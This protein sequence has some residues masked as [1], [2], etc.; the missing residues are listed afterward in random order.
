M[1][2][3]DRPGAATCRT[4][5]GAGGPATRSSC[6]PLSPKSPITLALA[7]GVALALAAPTERASAQEAQAPR[8]VV[9]LQEALD[10]AL[11][12]NKDLA[13]YEYRVAEQQGRLEQAGLLPNPQLD[14]LIEDVAGSG[15]YE[16]FDS[17]QTTISLGWVLE[18]WL[19][20]GRVR[21]AKAGAELVSAKARILRIEVAADTA[22][23]FLASL[24]SQTRLER[25]DAAIELAERTVAA[26]TRRVRAGKAPTVELARAEAELAMDRLARDDV[27]HELSAAHH[28]LAAQWGETEPQF[29]HVAGD[30]LTLPV[31]KARAEL[32]AGLER[33]PQLERYATEER[34]AQANLRLAEARRWPAPK[35]LLGV[36]RYEAT[37]DM[38]LVAGVS[39][40]LPLLNRNQGEVAASRSSISRARAQTD[41][42][43]VRLQTTLFE[44]YEELQHYF[45][46]AETL[47]IEVIPRL[48][49][50]LEGTR[51]AYERGRYG[52]FELRSVQADLLQAESD[53]VEA[54]AGAHRLVIALERLAGERVVE[55]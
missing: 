52:Y 37:D 15:P 32:T 31:I 18:G 14:V 44:L 10:R 23:H 16:G 50:A 36:R 45:H 24:A 27:T 53:L 6:R 51:Q 34:L 46:R 8:A 7:C 19:R 4:R 26:V 22:E 54:S 17:A 55:K 20:S 42:A 43:R 1:Q 21:A 49:E 40:A 9:G 28:R 38:A 3:T 48:V 25:A 29:S 5:G 35:P 12:H 47:R 33:N 41:A 13:A 2:R 11:M 30:L 39:V